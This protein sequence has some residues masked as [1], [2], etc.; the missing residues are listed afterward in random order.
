MVS[1]NNFL[2]NIT[3]LLLLITVIY[4]FITMTLNLKNHFKI[5][6]ERSLLTQIITYLVLALGIVAQYLT[7]LI[8]IIKNN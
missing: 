2:L 3:N 4:Y 5:S 1:E 6:W 7:Y 8:S